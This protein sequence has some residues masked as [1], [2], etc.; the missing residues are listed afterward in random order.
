M[1]PAE[2]GAGNGW[3]QRF[4]A[5][6][7]S[8]FQFIGLLEPDGRLIEINETA[9]DFAGVTASEVAGQPFWKTAWWQTHM[10]ARQQLRKAIQRAAAGEF[11]RYETELKGLNGRLLAIDFSIKAVRDATGQVTM[12]I[13]EGRDISGRRDAEIALRESETLF[14]HTFDNAPIGIALVAPDGRW[15]VVNR[16]LPRIV[17]YSE[18]EL[19]A[20]SF[21]DITHPEDLDSDMALLEQ[22]LAG[23]RDGYT[24]D[25]RYIHKNGHVV[26]IQLD[27]SL[28]RDPQG[29]PQFFISQIQD[30]SE[31]KRYEDS[32]THEAHHDALT[33]LPNRRYF[34]DVLDERLY[35]SGM[36]RRRQTLLYLDLDRFKLI[37]DTCSHQAGDRVLRELSRLLND[38]LRHGD[39]LARLGGDEFAVIAD[40]AGPEEALRLANSLIQVVG[41]YRLVWEDR[42]F[43][44]G[45]SIGIALA[46]DLTR[47]SVELLKRADTACY[48]AKQR[49]RNRA[50]VYQQT[51]E[52]VRQAHNDMDWAS[53][54][55]QALDEDRMQLHAQKIVA[56][57]GRRNPGLEVLIRLREAGGGLIYPGAFIPAAIR[58]GL[59]GKLDRWIVQKTLSYLQQRDR[60]GDVGGM[61]GY[62]YL[63]LNLSG[64]SIADP[65]FRPLLLDT[66]K[67][68]EA[69][70]ARIC[71]EITEATAFGR[72]PAAKEL[73]EDLRE[74]GHRILLDDFG[75]GFTS[76][77]CLKSLQVDGI[78]VDQ[79]YT[80]DLVHD[81]VNQ[82]IV[83]SIC[84]IGQCL[85]LEVIAEGVEDQA[86]LQALTQLGVRNAQGHLFHV[87]SPLQ[88][89]LD[90]PVTLF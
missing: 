67:E 29:R 46:D 22:T 43:Q 5:I 52:E 12:L 28:K 21:Q 38:R 48:I 17:G 47:S 75:S 36:G 1:T 44:L 30:I 7:N 19:L 84:K 63:T 81:L 2:A 50:Q 8:M 35:S 32:L 66:L 72:Q 78:K 3:E 18:R 15:L 77:E 71:F 26:D 90:Q 80:R 51:D 59:A 11:V 41:T 55:E 9:L 58:F 45:L 65:D 37:N 60:G 53:K 33:G 20:M 6:F 54:L 82:T 70:P 27:V 57:D 39:V 13:A 24:M 88:Q 68:T 87:A 83:Q 89:L 64:S 25:K 49:G 76:F 14:R 4:R 61:G 16:A 79:S 42:Q 73:L 69:N 85:N 74:R 31:R 56:L 34:E 40:C 86:T 10:D 62:S 23:K